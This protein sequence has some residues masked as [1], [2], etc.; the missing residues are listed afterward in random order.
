[1]INV[2]ENNTTLSRVK[3]GRH[4]GRVQT[5]SE[6]EHSMDVGELLDQEYSA[7]P[8]LGDDLLDVE[9]L[10]EIVGPT[11]VGK[12]YL[13]L[14]LAMDLASGKSFLG[15]IT[16]TRPFKVL[17][18]QAEIGRQRFRG[19]VAKLWTNYPAEFSANLRTITAA[20]LKLDTPEGRLQMERE[21]MEHE[22]EVLIIDPLKCF[23]DKEENSN[24]GMDKVFSIF[25][26]LRSNGLA[27]VFTHHDRKP[28]E[29]Y[30]KK[31][32]LES[33]G[34]SVI[35]DRP[36]T[37]LALSKQTS[38]DKGDVQLTFAKMRNHEGERLSNIFLVIIE[39]TGLFVPNGEDADMFKLTD[40]MAL[41]TL[42]TYD[43]PPLLSDLKAKIAADWG[44][45]EKT[46]ERRLN[47]LEAHGRIHKKADPAD[48]R[49]KYIH[50]DQPKGAKA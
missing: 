4:K 25:R 6:I 33:R 10:M 43:A 19:R 2:K 9:G 36:D 45:G 18:V 42:N 3:K 44:F 40:V 29:S 30:G 27:I 35:T 34:A 46:V 28:S 21:I 15:R 1:M 47:T 39:A 14:Q 22:I 50:I 26:R 8:I 31:P 23:H 11:E 12:S 49:K 48:A 32:I 41:E 37:I 7:D 38:R 24:T 5:S 13:A 16:V 20:H 17:L